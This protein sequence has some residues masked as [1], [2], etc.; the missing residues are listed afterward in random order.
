MAESLWIL[1]AF[2]WAAVAL[3]YV[4]FEGRSLYVTQATAAGAWG[5]GAGLFGQGALEG[6][7]SEDGLDNIANLKYKSGSYTP[8]DNLLNPFWFAATERLPLWL[9]PNLVTLTGL[10]C[11]VAGYFLLWWHAPTFSETPESWIF[12]ANAVILWLY[13]V[14]RLAPRAASP[15]VLCNDLQTWQNTSTD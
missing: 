11:L 10:T 13:Q 5:F 1:L 4:V 2:L 3:G 12:L 6:P 7:L 15:S 14:R 9:A 8:L